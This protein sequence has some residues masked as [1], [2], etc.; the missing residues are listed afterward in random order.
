MTDPTN[1]SRTLLFDIDQKAFP[2]ELGELLHVPAAVLPKVGG[3]A[4][5]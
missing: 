3:S 5:D 1:A 4:A 2:E